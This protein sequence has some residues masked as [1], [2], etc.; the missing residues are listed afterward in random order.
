MLI[1]AEI[2]M[3]RLGFSVSPEARMA[4]LPIIGMTRNIMPRYQICM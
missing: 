3:I 2:V 4:L 1:T